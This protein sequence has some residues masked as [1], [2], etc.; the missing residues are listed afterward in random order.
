MSQ[1]RI[2]ARSMLFDGRDPA[3][4]LDGLH[5]Y[6]ESVEGAECATVVCAIVD[7]TTSVITYSRAGHLP[8]LVIG[9]EDSGTRWLDG[10]GGPPLAAIRDCKYENES[11]ALLT[12][13]RLILFSDGLVERR[14]ETIVDGLE[15][16]RVVADAAKDLPIHD[17]ADHILR[18]LRPD[19][20]ADDIVLVAKLNR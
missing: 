8:P 1:L 5:R 17:F 9:T 6:A 14:D 13:D 3:G 19:G 16:L 2:A 18:T 20:A 12:G 4:V 15:R 7:R 10:A 11:A